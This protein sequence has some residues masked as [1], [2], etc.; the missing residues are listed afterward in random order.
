MKTAKI[1]PPDSD[2]IAEF[3]Q[4]SVEHRYRDW[5]LCANLAHWAS[6]KDA[7]TSPG[8]DGWGI[9]PESSITIRGS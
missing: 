5:D 7:S 1:Q 4:R 2:T 8:S 6:V 3:F 9:R